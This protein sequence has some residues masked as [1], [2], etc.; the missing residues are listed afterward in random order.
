MSNISKAIIAPQNLFLCLGWID[1]RDLSAVPSISMGVCKPSKNSSFSFNTDYTTMELNTGWYLQR[2]VQDSKNIRKTSWNF[3]Q[4]ETCINFRVKSST[5]FWRL[6]DTLIGN[7]R[8]IGSSMCFPNYWTYLE[9][10][11]LQ[12]RVWASQILV[13]P[14]IYRRIDGKNQDAEFTRPNELLRL[15]SR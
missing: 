13:K 6:I 15:K 8:F 4:T 7:Q 5:T 3:F 10:V 2:I 11:E 9:V 12:Y 14:V 1:V